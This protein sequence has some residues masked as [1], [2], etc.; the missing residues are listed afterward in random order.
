MEPEISIAGLELDLSPLDPNYDEESGMIIQPA[1]SK[2]DI[3]GDILSDI[4]G[5]ALMFEKKGS[6]YVYE[7]EKLPRPRL[8]LRLP[9]RD[10][11]LCHQL[12]KFFGTGR[13]YRIDSCKDLWGWE[14]LAAKDIRVIVP[15]LLPFL[16]KKK[17][18][19]QRLLEYAEVTRS[20]T[21]RDPEAP[22]PQ[23][24]PRPGPNRTERRFAGSSAEE[25][26]EEL[27]WQWLGELLDRRGSICIY[28][29]EGKQTKF[30]VNFFNA[31]YDGLQRLADW[32][33]VGFVKD[34]LRRNISGSY[35]VWE[36][37]AVSAVEMRMLLPQ[38]LPY[39]VVRKEKVLELLVAAEKVPN[40]S[41]RGG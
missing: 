18:A 33:G 27:T 9:S 36:W 35:Y 7:N 14:T 32:S 40:R 21:P 38:I 6:F 1:P 28:Y 24:Y 31:D 34:H 2:E 17:E 10:L 13:V 29:Y 30:F 20:Y 8:T 39:M 15:A 4:Q 22:Q 37:R 23:P 26:P 16:S 5:V 19:A 25:I 12:Q 41:K 11:E 3:G